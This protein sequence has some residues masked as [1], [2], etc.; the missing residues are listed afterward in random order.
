MGFRIAVPSSHCTR[1][2]R[3]TRPSAEK[4]PPAQPL[5]LSAAGFQ[6]QSRVTGTVVYQRLQPSRF[7]GGVSQLTVTLWALAGAAHTRAPRA[8]TSAALALTASAP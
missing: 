5:V 6:V 8:T 2:E 4:V 7:A 1:Q 3:S